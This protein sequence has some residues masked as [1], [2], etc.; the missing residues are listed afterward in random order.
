MKNRN[1]FPVNLL[2]STMV[3]NK[4]IFFGFEKNDSKIDSEF[5]PDVKLLYY[6][7]D[8]SFDTFYNSIV[9]V[10]YRNKFKVN[11]FLKPHK[12]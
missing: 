3:K 11:Y 12:A 8:K 4:A 9:V 5:F 10:K 2:Y 7:N 1:E 6:I